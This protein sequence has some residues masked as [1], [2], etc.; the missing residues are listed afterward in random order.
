MK[1]DSLDWVEEAEDPSFFPLKRKRSFKSKRLEFIGWGSRPL[2]EFLQSIGRE[3]NREYSRHEVNAVVI[4]YVR[5]NNLVNPQKKKRIVCDERLRTLFGK[6]SIS[7]IKVYDLLETH[8]VEN[9]D[10]SEEENSSSEDVDG[11]TGSLIISKER[12]ISAQQKKIQEAP[13]SSFAALTSENIKLVYLK[14]SLVQ[15]LLK[16]Q[17]NF[18]NKVV[19]SFV[20]I[21][22]DPYDFFQKNSHQLQQVTGV[23][24]TFQSVD[25][26]TETYLQLSSWLRDVSI[27]SLSDDDF[28]E[29]E[30]EDL[31]ERVK[32]GL[33]KRPT[34]VDFELKAHI[35]HEDITRHWIAREI[36]LLQ[37]RIDHANEKGWRRIARVLAE[38]TATHD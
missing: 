11:E 24:K 6:K 32:G 15:A 21:K 17:E 7:R 3:T 20:R 38:K 33:L 8:F 14:R 37:R 36:T 30:C 31:S 25:T 12:K 5:S 27:S 26:G 2:I 23:K 35:L 29:E 13:K 28:T 16:T 9:Q 22:S 4:D 19:G 18:D 34:V 1:S 10:E